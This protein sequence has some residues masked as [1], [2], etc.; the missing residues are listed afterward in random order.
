MSVYKRYFR[1][2]EGPV[3]DEIE[4]LFELRTAASKLYNDLRDKYQAKD[5]RNYSHNGAFAG[6]TFKVP[7]DITVYRFL[8][9]HKLWV[10]RRKGPGAEIWKEIESLPT[11]E[12]IENALKLVGLTPNVP[13]IFDG[14]RWYA[15][16]LWGFGEPTPVWFISVP[17]KDVDPAEL[18]QY[19]LDRD[20]GTRGGSN[21]E[22]LSW[23]VP[24]GWAE[25]KEW[26]ITKESEEINAAAA[27]TEA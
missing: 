25:V 8:K 27:K 11:P 4:R 18:A 2:T 13:C 26:Q 15:P 23:E 3:V 12:P 7:P 24:E 14:G 22:H 17:W 19:K 9:K 1:I 5:V 20:A 21:L 6:F 10:P 16:T